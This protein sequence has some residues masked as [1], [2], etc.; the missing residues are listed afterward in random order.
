MENTQEIN[1]NREQ[2]DNNDDNDFNYYGEED[3]YYKEEKIT[4]EDLNEIYEEIKKNRL[5]LV[6]YLDE[7]ETV[8]TAIKRLKPLPKKVN[9]KLKIDA[10]QAEDEMNKK[11]NETKFKELIDIIS[12]L[13]ELSYFDVYS[14]TIEKVTKSYGVKGILKWK[15]RTV[16]KT[17]EKENIVEYGPFK[18]EEIKS[19]VE[20]VNI[21]I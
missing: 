6:D 3:L 20:K 7:E 18:T 1:E 16:T 2:N 19:W 11:E 9:K 17:E 5:K 14:D 13:T 10:D 4:K 8:Q 15:Y 21:I 12:K